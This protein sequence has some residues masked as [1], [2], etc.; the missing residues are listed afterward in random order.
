MKKSIFNDDE[1]FLK[2][3]E[4]IQPKEIPE[5]LNKKYHKKLKRKI[6]RHRLSPINIQTKFSRLDFSLGAI[7][8]CVVL[9]TGAY[10]YKC[11]YLWKFIRCVCKRQ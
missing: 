2:W 10:Y 7:L 1:A 4:D 9:V 5:K 6:F 8:I 3:I 11:G